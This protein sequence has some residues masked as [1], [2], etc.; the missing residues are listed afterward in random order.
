[1]TYCLWL[2]RKKV[3]DA[4]EIEANFDIASLRGYYLAGSLI[5]WLRGHG[6]ESYADYLE[7]F[8]NSDDPL[9]NIMLAMAFNQNCFSGETFAEAVGI[10][11]DKPFSSCFEISSFGSATSAAGG[12]S[13]SG[14]SGFFGYGLD[15][16]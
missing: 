8:T 3:K 2:N 9:L 5:P 12:A 14:T 10:D 6:G 7:S 4:S 11:P 15:I 1:M 13:F 16:V